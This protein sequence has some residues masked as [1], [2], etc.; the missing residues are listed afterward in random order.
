MFID[1]WR[2]R[3]IINF[4]VRNEHDKEV[5]YIEM[6]YDDISQ[7]I[8]FVESYEGTIN[9]KRELYVARGL[10]Q[11]DDTMRLLTIFTVILLPLTLIAGNLWY[12][13]FRSK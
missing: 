11:I 2:V 13:W 3:N 4:I 5:K 8:D 10:L 9:S 12:E 6:V 1:F 7:L